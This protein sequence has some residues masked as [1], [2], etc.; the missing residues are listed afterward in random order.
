M[1]D[2]FNILTEF[3]DISNELKCRV[4]FMYIPGRIAIIDCI[5]TLVT[6]SFEKASLEVVWSCRPL[7]PR[8]SY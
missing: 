2:I 8:G 3:V 4:F 1:L 7:V 5:Y 6:K